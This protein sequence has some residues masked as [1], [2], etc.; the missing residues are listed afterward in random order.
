[1]L[2][3]LEAIFRSDQPLSLFHRFIMEFLNAAAGRT[4]EMVMVHPVIQ[5]ING[6]P[7]LEVRLLEQA[8]LL[9]LSEH[10]VHGSQTDLVTLLE[11]QAIRL[12][13]R[14]M[15]HLRPLKEFEN[16]Q[17]RQRGLEAAASEFA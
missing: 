13:G 1:M 16:L 6:S 8:G 15:P 3:D 5:L 4:H 17:A 14:Q 12:F 7:C 9:Q 11:Q 10:A 2:D